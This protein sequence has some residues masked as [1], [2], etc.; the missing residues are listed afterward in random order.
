MERHAG[1]GQTYP[2]IQAAYGACEDGDTVVI[3]AG[4]FPEIYSGG[5]PYL[6]LNRAINVTFKPYTGD[7]VTITGNVGGNSVS[8]RFGPS[9]GGALFTTADCGGGTL[10]IGP[11]NAAN[12]MLIT[13]DLGSSNYAFDGV[14]FAINNNNSYIFYYGIPAAYQCTNLTL[15]NCTLSATGTNSYCIYLKGSAANPQSGITLTGCTCNSTLSN[16]FIDEGY[17]TNLSVSYG[18]HTENVNA[19]GAPVI[20]SLP[21]SNLTG[22][23]NVLIYKNKIYNYNTSAQDR[24]QGIS[25]GGTSGISDVSNISVIENEIWTVDPVYGS[26]IHIQKWAFNITIRDNICYAADHLSRISVASSRATGGTFTISVRNENS[27]EDT[28]INLPAGASAAAIESALEGLSTVGAGNVTCTDIGGGLAQDGGYVDIEF[29]RDIGFVARWLDTSLLTGGD[30]HIMG[31][32]GSW[33]SGVTLGKHVTGQN[34]AAYIS[35]FEISGGRLY[36]QRGG[37]LVFGGYIQTG[38][39][40]D[41]EV[42]GIGAAG[43]S[44]GGGTAGPVMNVLV[45]NIRIPGFVS[46]QG[47][48]LYGY[49]INVLFD[50]IYAYTRSES[51]RQNGKGEVPSGPDAVNVI[52]QNFRAESKNSSPIMNGGSPT[53]EFRYGSIR[54]PLQKGIYNWGANGSKVHHIVCFA[55]E[56]VYFKGCTNTEVR[57]VFCTVSGTSHGITF[58]LAGS[59]KNAGCSVT[60]STFILDN[61]AGGLFN[62]AAGV[63]DTNEPCIVRRNKYQCGDRYGTLFGNSCESLEEARTAWD[64]YYPDNDSDSEIGIGNIFSG[65]AGRRQLQLN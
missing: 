14:N 22:V 21:G 29:A 35:N 65:G 55:D 60:R 38:N 17:V 2:T 26:C 7:A 54:S 11:D 47:V 31:L 13:S 25:F 63:I 57:N 18:I 62:I 53:T 23:S 30:A 36:G 16:I 4:V 40:H 48:A 45:Q 56:P 34:T 24:C 3:H 9:F 61:N 42:F 58:A 1:S 50:E 51:L 43:I 27:Q 12:T 52:F 59:T 41:L 33:A 28:T 15:T 5:H 20:G 44:I 49:C 8:I 19:T 6:Y 32:S 46:D 37:G 10:T 64:P 39:I